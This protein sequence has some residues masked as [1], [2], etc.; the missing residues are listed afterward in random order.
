MFI[1]NKYNIF[2]QNKCKCKVVNDQR[3][4]MDIMEE[5]IKQNVGFTCSADSKK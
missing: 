5:K 2:E 3:K 4:L 1:I